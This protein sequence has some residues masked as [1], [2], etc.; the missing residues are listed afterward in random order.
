[1][2]RTRITNAKA[3]L[4]EGGGLSA[5]LKAARH[6]LVLISRANSRY[7]YIDGCKFN[8][9]NVN[10]ETMRLSLLT[11]VY[12][13]S[14]RRAIAKYLSPDL[15]VIELGGCIGVVACI[16]NRSLRNPSAHL[17]VE[18]NPL[19]AEQLHLNKVENGCGFTLINRAVDYDSST[20]TFRPSSDFCGNSVDRDGDLSPV[21]VETTQLGQILN[22][23]GY[24]RYTLICDIEGR[25]YDLVFREG[26]HLKK[27]DLIILETHARMIGETK[28]AAMMDRLGE[29]GFTL[30]EQFD[31][32]SV[33]KPADKR[34]S[35]E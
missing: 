10:N 21:T 5:L 34:G 12:E 9:R 25:E 32:V 29:L 18:A 31:F 15:P 22:Q 8:L 13:E 20:V 14:E 2:L 6:R 28:N 27:A 30:V 23:Q 19:A 3:L 33:L 16:T 26:D 7:F 35:E 1:M 17:I 24:E 11:G 4:R